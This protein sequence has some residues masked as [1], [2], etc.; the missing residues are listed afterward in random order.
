MLLILV[1][2]LSVEVEFLRFLNCRLLAG[3]KAEEPE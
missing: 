1:L 2:L 3:P